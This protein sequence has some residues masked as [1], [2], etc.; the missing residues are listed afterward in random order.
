[1]AYEVVWHAQV[2]KD[3]KA[4]PS[5]DAARIIAQ[6]RTRLAED[7]SGAGK[8]LSG[9]FKGLMRFRVG[10]C[11]VIYAVDHA[12]RL[13]KIL[14]IRPRDEAYRRRGRAD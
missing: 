10:A 6:V 12:A 3:L 5:E 7:P 2:R 14:N 13:V 9:G 8:P 11:R 4:I 1:L